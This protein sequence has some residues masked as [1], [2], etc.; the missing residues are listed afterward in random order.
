MTQEERVN[1]AQTIVWFENWS[2]EVLM[3]K[4]DEELNKI[5]ERVTSGRRG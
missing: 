5:F 1:K 2:F 3:S 4:S